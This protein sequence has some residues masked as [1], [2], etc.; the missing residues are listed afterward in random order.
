[1]VDPGRNDP[2]PCGSGRKWKVCCLHGDVAAKEPA[3]TLPAAKR[4]LMV[5]SGGMGDALF[6]LPTLLAA[7]DRADAEWRRSQAAWMVRSGTVPILEVI[8]AGRPDLAEH[9]EPVVVEDV[10]VRVGWDAPPA[11][12]IKAYPGFHG[13]L[14]A[15][16]RKAPPRDVHLTRW[17]GHLAGVEPVSEPVFLSAAGVAA[18]D[19]VAPVGR[20]VYQPTCAAP[21]LVPVDLLYAR[22]PRGTIVVRQGS[23]PGLP[24][25]LLERYGYEEWVNRPLATVAATVARARL[26][27]G[28]SGLLPLLAAH[29]R[30]PAVMVHEGTTP[31]TCG[32]TP[33][34]GLDLLAPRFQ[35]ALEVLFQRLLGEA[36]VEQEEGAVPL[37][38]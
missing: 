32:I 21:E 36:Y 6:A 28:C 24:A 12:W 38:R 9:L 18:L 2:C 23:D 19:P 27:V 37:V 30:V 35:G 8:R 7:K 33:W 10:G 14:N 20:V 13:A 22:L 4:F 5:L 31:E 17:I 16:I 3:F 15:S 29:L 11:E 34:G 1:M 26:V 25:E